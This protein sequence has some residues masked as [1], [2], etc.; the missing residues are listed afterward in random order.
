MPVE[1]SLYE[2]D[3]LFKRFFERKIESDWSIP[4]NWINMKKEIVPHMDM[5]YSEKDNDFLIK[6]NY[7]LSDYDRSVINTYFMDNGM[8]RYDD[9]KGQTFK[10]R[11]II[12]E[13]LSTKPKRKIDES[14]KIDDNDLIIGKYIA[15]GIIT[16][17]WDSH[18]KKLIEN[19]KWPR[20]CNDINKYLFETD[21]AEIICIESI[22]KELVE[23]YNVIS[24]RVAILYHQDRNLKVSTHSNIY[25]ARA[26][27][28]LLIQGYEEIMGIAFGNYKKSLDIDLSTLTFKESHSIDGI[29]DWDEDPDVR[30]TIDDIENENIKKLVRSLEKNK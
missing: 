7:R 23:L 1:D 21:L 27:Y 17:I 14:I 9:F 29:Y 16:N 10:I 6:A 5:T 15:A 3:K 22:K 11:S 12:G 25:L 28:E 8:G 20:Q 30:T 26:N 13:Y 4:K 18:T 2:S 24:K 19:H